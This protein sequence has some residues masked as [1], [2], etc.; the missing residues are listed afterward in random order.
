MAQHE[1]AVWSVY[2]KLRTA[3]LNVK[4][5]CC[6]LERAEQWAAIFQIILL[7]SAPTSAIGS[8]WFWNSEIGKVAWQWLG[9]IAAFTSIANAAYAPNKKIKLYEGVLVG[10]RNLEFDLMEIRSAIEQKGK[11]DVSLQSE[12]RKAIQ[13]E[14]ALVGKNPETRPSMRVLLRCEEEVRNELPDSCFFIPELKN[15]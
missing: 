11:Y 15:D 7:A 3:R 14:K 10:Y 4:Y 6:R 2:D 9:A 5:Y 13:R 8:L 1:Q 12:F